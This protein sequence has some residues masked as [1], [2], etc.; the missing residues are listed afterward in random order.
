M[1]Q[2]Q[3]YSGAYAEPWNTIF[4]NDAYQKDEAEGHPNLLMT[5]GDL[6]FRLE[7]IERR[8]YKRDI[9]WR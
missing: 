2:I 3:E 7:D 1:G 8:N 4:S 9:P 5:I 6:Y